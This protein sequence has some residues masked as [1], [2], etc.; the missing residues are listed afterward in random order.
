MSVRVEVCSRDAGDLGLRES[1]G[2]RRRLR[3]PRPHAV[4]LGQP[5]GRRAVDFAH[6]QREEGGRPRKG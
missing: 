2:P 6:L 5:D 3:E 1:D 4:G